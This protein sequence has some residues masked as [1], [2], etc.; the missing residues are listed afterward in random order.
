VKTKEKCSVIN[1]LLMGKNEILFN[2]FYLIADANNPASNAVYQKVGYT[3]QGEIT[4]FQF[5][6]NI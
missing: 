3:Y 2:L 1:K 6:S 5:N 4:E